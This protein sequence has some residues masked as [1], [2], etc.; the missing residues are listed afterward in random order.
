MNLAERVMRSDCNNVSDDYIITIVAEDIPEN[1]GENNQ[2]KVPI[3]F[4][5]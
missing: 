5:V 3:G 1:K 2:S 4:A